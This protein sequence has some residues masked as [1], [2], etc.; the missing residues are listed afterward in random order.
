MLNAELKNLTIWLNTNKLTVNVKKKH[1]TWC[2]ACTWIKTSDIEVVMQNKSINCVTSTK[3]LGIVIDNKLKWNKHIAYMYVKNKIS[4]AV[5][6]LYKIR[7]F[8]DKSTLL[9]MYIFSCVS[10]SYILY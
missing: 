2:F 1:I 3:S 9:N 8:L 7:K 10:L 4:K 6:V 5:G